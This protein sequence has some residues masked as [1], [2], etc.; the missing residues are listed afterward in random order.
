MI[1][2]KEEWLFARYMIIPIGLPAS[3]KTSLYNAAKPIEDFFELKQIGPDIQ[4]EKEYP[5]Y[6]AGKIPFCDIDNRRV[7]HKAEHLAEDA[8]LYGDSV[9]YDATN[10]HVNNRTILYHRGQAIE[11]T[12]SY[13]RKLLY[14]LMYLNVPFDEILKRN[15]SRGEHRIPE[16]ETLEVWQE[17]FQETLKAIPSN[18]YHSTNHFNVE[19]SMSKMDIWM[20]NWSESDGWTSNSPCKWVSL[21]DELIANANE[22]D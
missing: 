3:G 1:S 7:M 16:V 18:P 14:I 10:L 17:S 21:R 6:E 12:L 8:L 15:E 22:G 11:N 9:Y 5:G 20:L 4:R 2:E 19:C 13:H